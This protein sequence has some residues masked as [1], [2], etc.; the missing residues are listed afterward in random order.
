MER[1][2][3]ARSSLN[4]PASV[5]GFFW[6]AGAVALLVAGLVSNWAGNSRTILTAVLGMSIAIAAVLGIVGDR[7]PHWALHVGGACSIGLITTCAA[8]G[9]ANHYDFAILYVWIIVY[10]ALYF[11]PLTTVVYAVSTAVV[12]ATLLAVGPAVPNPVANWLAVIGTGIV[13]GVVILELVGRLRSEAMQDLLTHLPNRRA[14]D[15]RIEEELERTRRTGAPLSV[16]MI[17]LDGFK[18]INDRLGH[19]AGDALLQDLALAWQGVIRSGGDFLA[20]LGGDEFGVLA[21]GS[22]VI[23]MCQLAKRLEEAAPEG[24]AFSIGMASWDGRDNSG[25]LMRRADQSMYQ[26]KLLHHPLRQP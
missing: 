7:L 3:N 10:S 19:D 13:T 11:S 1:A 22:D 14:W 9:T 25:S 17:D 5:A 6:G 12:Y 21:P 24:T 15:E 2:R 20:R 18:A 4:H 26:E 23:G 16:A 8:I